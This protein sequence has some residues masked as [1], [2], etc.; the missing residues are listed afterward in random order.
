M[1]PLGLEVGHNSGILP[2]LLQEVKK[3]D[4][5]LKMTT[6]ELLSKIVQSQHGFEYLKSHSVLSKLAGDIVEAQSDQLATVL[7]PGK[8]FIHNIFF[9]SIKHIHTV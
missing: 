8:M 6:L 3:D 9:L 5:L 2:S 1:K 7:L 4:I